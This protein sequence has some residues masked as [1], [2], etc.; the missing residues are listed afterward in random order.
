MAKIIPI[1]NRFQTHG[2]A[3]V[4]RASARTKPYIANY[5]IMHYHWCPRLGHQLG[6]IVQISPFCNN[7][8]SHTPCTAKSDS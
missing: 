6:K 8:L 7:F 5:L 3:T 1:Q 2:L 4:V